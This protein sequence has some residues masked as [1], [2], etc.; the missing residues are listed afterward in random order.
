VWR[1]AG[2]KPARK[3]GSHGAHWS[4]HDVEMDSSCLRRGSI[5]RSRA[6]GMDVAI[7]TQLASDRSLPRAARGRTPTLCTSDVQNVVVGADQPLAAHENPANLPLQGVPATPAQRPHPAHPSLQRARRGAGALSR[8]ATPP[9]ARKPPAADA[10][11]GEATL[12]PPTLASP[13]TRRRGSASRQDRAALL[14]KRA[15]GRAR[16]GVLGPGC[17]AALAGC[18][19]RLLP[20]G[21]DLVRGPASRGTWPST[22]PAA[23]WPRR[24]DPREGVQPR[25][26][27]LRVQGTANSPLSTVRSAS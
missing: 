1:P 10:H 4:N 19:L 27:G 15:P 5:Q 24:P 23:Y 17:S 8:P 18:R 12:R 11:G 16:R 7:S 26:S 2:T 9:R 13:A 20:S 14:R 21:P 22:L 3:C 25:W 6:G